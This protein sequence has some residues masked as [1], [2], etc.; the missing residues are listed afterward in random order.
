[1]NDEIQFEISITPGVKSD[2]FLLEIRQALGAVVA[3][4]IV[5]ENFSK[6]LERAF[7]KTANAMVYVERGGQPSSFTTEIKS[8]L[9]PISDRHGISIRV[10]WSK[11]EVSVVP[12]D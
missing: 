1:M 3:R 7:P 12:S 10:K 6:P 8:A 4:Q 11:G 2:E 5:E 9:R